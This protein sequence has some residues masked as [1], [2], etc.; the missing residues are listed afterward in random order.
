MNNHL[1]KYLNYQRSFPL[2]TFKKTIEDLENNTCYQIGKLQEIEANHVGNQSLVSTLVA[3]KK[4]T[5][6]T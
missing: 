4:S 5:L 6:T 1:K 2:I 3:K